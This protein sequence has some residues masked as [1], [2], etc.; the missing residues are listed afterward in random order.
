MKQ[1]EEKRKAEMDTRGSDR[2][3][4]GNKERRSNYTGDEKR[5]D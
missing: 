5:R 3:D 1:S 4:Y 2:S